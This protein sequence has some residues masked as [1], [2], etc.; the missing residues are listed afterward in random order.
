MQIADTTKCVYSLHCIDDHCSLQYY[1]KK[2]LN[3]FNPFLVVRKDETNQGK[4]VDVHEFEDSNL[5]PFTNAELQTIDDL[6]ELKDVLQHVT[7][8]KLLSVYRFW[9][10]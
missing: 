8:G 1:L 7:M 6:K 4:R 10:S 9:W 3:I 5:D 2:L